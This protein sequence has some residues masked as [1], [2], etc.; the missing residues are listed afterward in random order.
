M[1]LTNFI[2]LQKS[3]ICDVWNQRTL[4]VNPGVHHGRTQRTEAGPWGSVPRGLPGGPGHACPQGLGL[5]K[6]GGRLLRRDSVKVLFLCYSLS[7]MER[8]SKLKKGC[9]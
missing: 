3:F 8:I 4:E 9:M 7:L 6:A 2:M 1:T 5:D